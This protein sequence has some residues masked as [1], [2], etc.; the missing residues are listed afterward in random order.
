VTDTDKPN[1]PVVLQVL[2]SLETGGAERGCIDVAR[3]ITAH[4]GTALVASSGGAMT[5]ELPR[6]DARHIELPLESKNPFTMRANVGRLVRLIRKEKVDLIHARSRAPAWSALS[7]SRRCRIPFVTTFHGVYG[8]TNPFKKLY[9]SVMVRSDRVIAISQY[10][11]QHIRDTYHIDPDKVRVVQR[12]V[13]LEIFTPEAVS[14]ARVIKLTTDWRLEDGMPVIL[15][16]AR[17]SRLKGHVVL[18][19][20]LAELGR[21]DIRCLIVGSDQG[22]TGYRRELEA[23]VEKLGLQAIVHITDH[24]DD[25]AAAYKLSD[26]VVSASVEPEGFGRTVVEAQA[27]GRPVIATNI[28][29]TAETIID[30]ETGWLTPPGDAAALAQALGKA[31]DLNEYQRRSMAE[32]AIAHV[33]QNFSRERMTADTLA[34]YDELLTN[35]AAETAKAVA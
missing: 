18:M 32:R 10:I 15:M 13:D 34:I 4:G 5:R 6:I 30:G 20:A 17:L 25:M 16:P 35:Q 19:K 23:Q 12:G 1:G 28:G 24:C 31:L 27:L 33:S 14:P 8:A 29:A 3:A 2:P 21:S 26:V 22:R 7:A 9:N 11:G